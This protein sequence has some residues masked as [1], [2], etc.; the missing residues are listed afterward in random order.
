LA[1]RRLAQTLGGRFAQSSIRRI[2]MK[3]SSAIINLLK[4]NIIKSIY[5]N[6]HHF[7]FAGLFKFPIIMQYGSII[8]GDRNSILFEKPLQFNMLTLKYKNKISIQKGGRIILRGTKACFNH[9]NSV[10][11]GSKGVFEIG[12]QFMANGLAEFNCRKRLVF[13]DGCL[14]SVHTM[15]LDTDYHTITTMDGN[16][17]NLDKDIVIGNRVWVGCNVTILKGTKIGNDIVI[18]AGSLL[19]GDY[20][21]NNSIYVGHNPAKPIKSGIIWRP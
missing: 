6:Y 10:L 5:T 16:I 7:G 3:I 1:G 21:E 2:L 19:S 13:G 14:T 17:I 4:V 9:M 15:F 11:V 20:C 8:Q 18:G 12:D